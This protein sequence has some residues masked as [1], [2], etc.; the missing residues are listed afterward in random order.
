M[1]LG[2]PQMWTATLDHISVCIYAYRTPKYLQKMMSQGSRNLLPQICW[3]QKP[4]IGGLR[5]SWSRPLVRI[6]V[7]GPVIMHQLLLLWQKRTS[8]LQAALTDVF[9]LHPTLRGKGATSDKAALCADKLMVILKHVREND[10]HPQACPRSQVRSWFLGEIWHAG[11]I[12]L[13]RSHMRA[14]KHPIP[15]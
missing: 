4:R 7:G 6:L 2:S 13:A 5:D 14:H 10:G 3:T 1:P 11:N 12:N 9:H 15:S 8:D